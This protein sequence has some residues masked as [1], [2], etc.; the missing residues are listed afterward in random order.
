MQVLDVRLSRPTDS[1]DIAKEPDM[2]IDAQNLQQLVEAPS[3]R[4]DVELKGWLDL[5]GSGHRG[6]LA[7]ALIALANHG[8]G[9]VVIGFDDHGDPAENRPDSLASYGQDAINDVLDRF[10]DP[11]FHCN[12]QKVA[13]E[14]D[15]LE[16]P[17]ILVPGGHK[18]PIRSRRGSP[19][20]EIQANRYYVRRPG[21]ASEMPQGG[22][23]WDELIRRCVRNNTDEIAS[24]VR[25]VLE[26]RA[27]R[28][29][30]PPD[31]S[32]RLTQLDA[33]SVARWME[34]I[35]GFP[36]DSHVRMPH[37]HYR[38]SAVIEGLNLDLPRLR[39]VMN[40]A[41]QHLTGWPPWWWPTREGIA[42]R[43]VG[44]TIECHIANQEVL[45]DAAHSDYWRVLTSGELFLIRG[46]AEDSLE[47]RGRAVAP[48]TLFDFTLPI[49]RIGECLLFIQRFAAESDAADSTVSVCCDWTGLSGRRLTVLGP[50]R[51]I[52][53]D[54]RSHSDNYSATITVPVERI[55]GAL[56][57]IVR[58]L[59]DPLYALFDFFQPPV[60]AY[61]EE[62]GRM[63]RREL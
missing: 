24:L 11:A 22:H 28:A 12:V 30:A 57:E 56:P 45:A 59:V 14:A 33:D 18:V 40:R 62:L 52:F 50:R 36:A 5:S 48:G 27:P 51:H 29:D 63:Q 49:W 37:G 35:D 20:N 46:H 55:S 54:Y 13:R 43:V 23:E 19:D 34:L 21:P 26:G 2:A 41:E 16:Y 31:A 61:A 25:D 7:K 32:A 4:L 44:N 15:G 58:E 1:S 38:V 53:R 39:D 47:Q 6:A 42:P 17:V 60:E 10:A 9:V 3:E 8:G